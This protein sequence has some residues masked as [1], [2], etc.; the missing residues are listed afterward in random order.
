MLRGAADGENLGKMRE[1]SGFRA[2]REAQEMA[3]LISAQDQ[4][5]VAYAVARGVGRDGDLV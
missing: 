3:T 4:I 5:A 2:G 1:I